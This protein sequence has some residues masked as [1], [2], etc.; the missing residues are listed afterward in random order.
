MVKYNRERSYV[1]K[2]ESLG[3]LRS[4]SFESVGLGILGGLRGKYQVFR[5]EEVCEEALEF[6]FAIR[7]LC[8]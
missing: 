8:K 5:G 6:I 2:R 4:E 7:V 1:I 3:K